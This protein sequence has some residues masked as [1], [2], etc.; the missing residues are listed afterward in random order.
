MRVNVRKWHNRYYMDVDDIKAYL[1]KEA[2]TSKDLTEKETLLALAEVFEQT[3]NK[4][5]KIL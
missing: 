3:I 2:N 4:V 5:R 1:Y